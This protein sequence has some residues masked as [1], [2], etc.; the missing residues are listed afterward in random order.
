MILVFVMQALLGLELLMTL[1]D[2]E[3]PA[4]SCPLGGLLY[5]LLQLVETLSVFSSS[6]IKLPIKRPA[7]ASGH[8]TFRA[9]ADSWNLCFHVRTFCHQNT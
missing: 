2:L 8:E 7:A 6:S 9:L 5:E 1:P 3:G 4:Q